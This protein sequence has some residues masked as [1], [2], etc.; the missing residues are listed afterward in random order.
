[1]KEYQ[2]TYTLRAA[3]LHS[4][5]LA[6]AQLHVSQ[7]SVSVQITRLEQEL[8]FRIFDRDRKTG[9]TLTRSGAA[10]LDGMNRIRQDYQALLRRC[11]EQSG[12]RSAARIGFFSAWDLS[13]VLPGVRARVA[14]Q[15]PECM[16]QM[17]AYS[18]RELV[19][20][21]ESGDLDAILSVRTAVPVS[22]GLDVTLVGQTHA[23]LVYAAE[24]PLHT[25]GHPV[26]AD[27]HQDTFFVQPSEECP[28]STDSNQSYFLSQMMQPRV[29]VVPN[30]ET[31][32]SRIAEGGGYG[33]FDSISRCLQY[34][35][36]AALP[37]D[38]GIS[39]CMAQRA[40][41]WNPV[42]DAFCLAVQESMADI[43]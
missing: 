21:L 23:V 8:G 34:D 1:M 30:L 10:F 16:L 27:F 29:E 39:L 4:I 31:M 19:E 15:C 18:F 28:Y 24:H 7:P 38:S 33:V 3:Q 9:L 43:V 12:G 13:G 42:V 20:R 40:G 37:L 2:L 26:L 14:E 35:G 6:A 5:S 25:P 22:S 17:E 36:L 32:L 11:A 41:S